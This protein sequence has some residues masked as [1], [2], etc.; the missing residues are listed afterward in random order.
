MFH[1]LLSKSSLDY[2]ILDITYNLYDSP[3]SFTW[4]VF[5]VEMVLNSLNLGFYCLM[6]MCFSSKYFQRIHAS[7]WFSTFFVIICALS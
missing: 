3:T 2:K 4:N 6:L 7:I 5:H 1:D